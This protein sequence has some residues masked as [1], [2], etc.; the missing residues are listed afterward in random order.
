MGQRSACCEPRSSERGEKEPLKEALESSEVS[1]KRN[2]FAKRGVMDK[3]IA[4][5]CGSLEAMQQLILAAS[6]IH[7]EVGGVDLQ[8]FKVMKRLG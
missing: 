6:V 8:A 7:P 5:S 3:K 4:G 2:E 1:F